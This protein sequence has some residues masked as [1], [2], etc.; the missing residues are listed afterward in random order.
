M[1]SYD[2]DEDILRRVWRLTSKILSEGRPA[3]EGLHRTGLSLTSWH[4]YRRHIQDAR[5]GGLLTDNE[6]SSL[7][8]MLESS[9]E[10][11]HCQQESVRMLVNNLKFFQARYGD[12][13]AN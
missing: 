1:D 4:S 6:A 3:A 11:T 8:L 5:M 7:L 9:T 13:R 12:L 10:W 2:S